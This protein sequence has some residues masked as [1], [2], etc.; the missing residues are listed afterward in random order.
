MARVDRSGLT[1]TA[2]DD[3]KGLQGVLHF[4]RDYFSHYHYTPALGHRLFGV[5]MGSLVD[6]L[7]VFAA[8]DGLGLLVVTWPNADACV[9][10]E[11]THESDDEHRPIKTRMYCQLSCE[12]ADAPTDH[13]AAMTAPCSEILIWV[14]AQ[15]L[16]GVSRRVESGG[17]CR[18]MPPPGELG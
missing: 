8:S 9:A 17:A 2:T 1:L 14:R 5:A 7:G 12:E 18:F 6:T 4:K 11:L 3:S 16:G 15:S 10:M 13:A